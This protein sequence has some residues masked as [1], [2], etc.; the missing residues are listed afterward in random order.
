MISNTVLTSDS[1]VKPVIQD[2]PK[3]PALH[4]L[5]R[6]IHLPHLP[7]DLLDRRIVVTRPGL[8]TVFLI[9]VATQDLADAMLNA[10]KENMV[11]DPAMTAYDH[12]PRCFP[13]VVPLH[14]PLNEQ[15]C[16]LWSE[17]YWPS[18][19]N[20]ASQ[21]LQDAPPLHQLRKVMSELDTETTDRYIK[22]CISVAAEA[23]RSGNGRSCGAVIV[24]PITKEVVAVAS[25]A[26]WIQ[27]D[28][29][30]QSDTKAGRPEYHALMRAISMVANKELRRRLAAGRHQKFADTCI[31]GIP[32]QPLH[33]IEAYYMES[34]PATT[35]LKSYSDLPAPQSEVRTE[36]YLCS[37]LDLYLTHE[38][39]VCCAMAMVHSR[40]RTCTFIS[41]MPKS[42]ALCAKI[43]PSVLGYGLFWRRELNWRVMTFQYKAPGENSKTAVSNEAFQA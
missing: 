37:G 25:D 42:G 1:I 2:A 30:T 26:R 40:F 36:G 31:E 4:H 28:G 20:P 8:P 16:K 10:L 35:L 21:V 19:F 27:Q 11:E 38:P 5:R 14:A 3:Q 43:S 41:R 6:L 13:I 32:G 17:R 23:Y 34:S 29:H 12:V 9:Q 18:I 39:C 24:E 22:L 33:P 15:Q 7:K